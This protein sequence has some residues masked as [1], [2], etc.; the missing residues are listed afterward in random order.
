MTD[1][2]ITEEMLEALRSVS[3][4]TL[5][6]QLLKRGM[7]SC[8]INNARPFTP[9]TPRIAGEAYTLRFVPFREDLSVPEVLGDQ[10]YP[11]RKAVEDI[12][13]GQIMVIDCRGVQTA[14]TIGDILALR[15]KIRGAAGVVTDGPV[16]DGAA[17]AETGL[18]VY[19]SGTVAPASIWSHFG[20]DLQCPVACGGATV[21]P[22]DVIVA[23]SDGAIV[24]PRKL[25][26]EISTGAVE[27]EQLEGFLKSRIADGHK[28]FGTYP[29]DEETLAA[30]ADWQQK[31]GKH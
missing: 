22:G 19:C 23:D 9:D 13:P 21:F 7:R 16:R 6:M 18:P 12:P 28:S 4:A 20:A 11:P 1:T 31:N 2:V 25:A 5:T 17:V 26:P 14:G 29:P 15:M 27:Q 24:L 30:Y 8:F 10:E 3:T